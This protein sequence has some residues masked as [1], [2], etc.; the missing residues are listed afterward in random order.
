MFC[1]SCD[2]LLLLVIRIFS[3]NSSS[4]QLA[5]VFQAFS[6]SMIFGFSHLLILLR[7]T[8]FSPLP[9]NIITRLL[10]KYLPFFISFLST[11]QKKRMEIESAGVWAT[12]LLPSPFLLF[13]PFQ[14]RVIIHFFAYPA[15]TNPSP[16][17]PGDVVG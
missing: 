2:L 3:S 12:P 1:F 10:I 15:F 13:S 11:F 9:G 16:C 4:C 8:F 7:L 14:P 5:S 17:C 6:V